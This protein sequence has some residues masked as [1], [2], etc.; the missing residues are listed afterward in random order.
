MV[1][2]KLHRH[3][4]FLYRGNIY[5]RIWVITYLLSVIRE[6]LRAVIAQTMRLIMHKKL[7]NQA[8]KE[9]E[10]LDNIFFLLFVSEDA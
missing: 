9:L 6:R 7:S 2:S 10:R 5:P 1:P 8:R 3:V 4:V